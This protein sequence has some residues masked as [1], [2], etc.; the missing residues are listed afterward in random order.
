LSTR[1]SPKDEAGKHRRPTAEE[2]DERIS[3]P[4]DPK[5]VIEGMMQVNAE[6]VRDAEPK[7]DRRRD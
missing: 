5:T 2:L 3:I 4:L 6:K 7:R 1:T